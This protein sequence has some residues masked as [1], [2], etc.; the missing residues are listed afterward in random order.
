[1]PTKLLTNMTPGRR[2]AVNLAACVWLSTC[3]ASEPIG[4]ATG[5]GP[6]EYISQEGIGFA[7]AFTD[8]AVLQRGGTGSTVYG[9]LRRSTPLFNQQVQVTVALTPSSKYTVGENRTLVQWVNS[10]YG[11]WTAAL[12]PSNA[13]SP[14][15]IKVTYGLATATIS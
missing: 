4:W 11:R 8:H 15:S 1:M 13:G 12:Q 14:V 6:T 2:Q 7:A 10:T 9:Y 3:V 5:S